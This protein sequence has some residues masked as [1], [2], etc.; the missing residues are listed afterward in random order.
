MLNEQMRV[1][2]LA[3]AHFR[4]YIA[5][6]TRYYFV[7][8]L[9]QRGYNGKMT[10]N[11]KKEELLLRVNKIRF[12]LSFVFCF[13]LFLNS[14]QQLQDALLERLRIYKILRGYISL[15]TRGCFLQY[16]LKRGYVGK[17]RMSH[18]NQTLQL[19]VT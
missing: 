6:R 14:F 10:F 17:I 1:R 2:Q 15:R 5:L 7:L 4:K 3:F 16:L 9:D 8:T 19:S 12:I 13:T 11:H 18:A